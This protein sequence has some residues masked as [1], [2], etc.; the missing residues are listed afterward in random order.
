[1]R[2]KGYQLGVLE[3]LAVLEE[4]TR[5]LYK[6]YADKLRDFDEFWLSLASDEATHAGWIRDLE[7]LVGNGTV[8]FDE[9]RFNITPILGFTEYVNDEWAA[10]LEQGIPLIKAISIALDI[11]KAFLEKKLFDVVEGDS[12]ELERTLNQLAAATMEHQDMLQKVW[13]K[14]REL[15]Q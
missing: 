12:L 13:N 4:T 3:T 11:E 5:D 14:H 10:V 1:M 6:A 2:R 9:G 8:D 15:H 7:P